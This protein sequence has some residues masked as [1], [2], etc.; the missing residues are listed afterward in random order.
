MCIIRK[1]KEEDIQTI[2]KLH[3]YNMPYSFN[4]RLGIRHLNMI[5][6]FLLN[7]NHN[8][9]FV[10]EVNGAVVGAVVMTFDAKL[11]SNVLLRNLNLFALINLLLKIIVKPSLIFDWYKAPSLTF[12]RV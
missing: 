5:Y 2:A 12:K 6:K 8:L 9:S 3:Q 10:A 11:F 1:L 7:S 4:S